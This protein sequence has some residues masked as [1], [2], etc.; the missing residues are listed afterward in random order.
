MESQTKNCKTS[1]FDGASPRNTDVHTED[2]QSVATV[3]DDSGSEDLEVGKGADNEN[4]ILKKHCLSKR[5]MIV[6]TVMSCLVIALTVG[7]F[8]AFQ[9]NESS[10]S[11]Q[12]ISTS[13][14]RDN[15]LPP[16]SQHQEGTFIEDSNGSNNDGDSLSI[17]TTVVENKPHISDSNHTNIPPMKDPTLDDVFNQTATLGD[18]DNSSN[19]INASSTQSPNKYELLEWP[20]LVGMPA[21]QA[22]LWLEEQYGE[23]TYDIIVVPQN[24]PVTI[25]LFV[26]DEGMIVEIPRNG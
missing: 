12:Q 16:T 4:S 1:S 6:F 19:G 3:E 26:N 7:L 11:G 17:N 2:H 15:T 10:S 18:D 13:G 21:E 20:N 25:R 5:A 14:T 9:E 23:D 22:K 24:S 8:Y